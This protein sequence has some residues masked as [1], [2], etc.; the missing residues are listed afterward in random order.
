MLIRK[1]QAIERSK[2]CKDILIKIIKEKTYPRWTNRKTNYSKANSNNKKEMENNYKKKI[3]KANNK[4]M[5]QNLQNIT[6]MG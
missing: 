5:K 6:N 2:Y 4:E 3:W 1:Y